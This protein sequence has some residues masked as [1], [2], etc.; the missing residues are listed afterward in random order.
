MSQTTI[1]VANVDG[2]AAEYRKAYVVVRDQSIEIYDRR[3]QLLTQAEG[4]TEPSLAGE[5]WTL[6]QEDGTVWTV[7]KLSTCGCGGTKVLPKA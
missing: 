5:R 7:D 2:P 6:T 3:R 1:N 4:P